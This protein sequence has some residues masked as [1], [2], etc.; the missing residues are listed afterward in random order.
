MLKR[1]LSITGVA[2]GARRR[3][4]AL[5]APRSI[6]S[7]LAR[8]RE[9]LWI[10]LIVLIAGLVHGYNMFGFPYYESDEGTYMSQAWAIIRLGALAPYTYWYDHAPGGWLQIAAWTM[11]TGGFRS[12]GAPINSGRVLML[13]MQIASVFMVYRIA[14]NVSGG[15]VAP[16][17]AALTFAL[18]AYGTYYHRRVVLDNITTCWML[19]SIVLLTEPDLS[20]KRVWLSGLALGISIL[21]KE[22]TIFLV[23][24]LAY[25]VWYRVRG[26]QRWFAV[27]GWVAIV[28]ALFSTYLLLAMLKG[29]LFPSGTWLG[30]TNAHVSLLD[31]LVY[32]TGR[33]R[34]GGLLDL[35]SGFWIAVRNWMPEEPLLLFGGAAGML[36]SVL[37][38]KW[39]RLVG[40]LGLVTISLWVFLGRGGIT[41]PFYLVPLL[42]LLALNL[43]LAVGL[44]TTGMRSLLRRFHPVGTLI[45]AAL[46]LGA[47]AAILACTLLGYSNPHLEFRSDPFVLWRSSQASVNTIA[48]NW[49]I[50]NI[51][52]GSRIIIDQAMWLDLHDIPGQARGFDRA[53]YYWK[54]QGDPAIRNGV[55]QGDWQ[56]AD[57]IVTTNQMLGDIH[58]LDD[59]LL[60]EVLRHSTLVTAF[61]TGGWPVEVRM[62]HKPYLP[63]P[64]TVLA[65]TWASYRA[66]FIEDGRVID[67]SSDGR[68]TSEGQAYALLRAVYV[69]DRQTF[70]AVWDWSTTNLQQPSGLLAWHWGT[71]ADGTTGVIDT[72]TASDADQDAALALLFARKRWGDQR[73]EQAALTLLNGIWEQTTTTAGGRRVLVAGNWARDDATHDPVINPSYFAPYAYR[74]FAEAD[75]RHDWLGLVDSSYDILARIRADARLGGPAGLAPNWV[76]LDATTGALRSASQFGDYANEYSYDASRLPWR[77]AVDQL[78]FSDPRAKIALEGLSLPEQAFQQNGKIAAAYD[79]N[80][81][82]TV[83]HEAISMYAGAMGS[84]MFARDRHLPDQIYT[85]KIMSQYHENGVEAYWGDP[86]GYYDQNWAWFATALVNGKLGN[87]WAG[88][89]E[90]FVH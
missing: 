5:P 58:R 47:V 14:R 60:N 32:Q 10:A 59:P 82:P 64:D 21:S 48:T 23:P 66:H 12:F 57:Y 81:A 7:W 41:L 69:D 72:G 65:K 18:S 35:N 40:V 71:R 3:D 78:W 73:Y 4:P 45:G 16:T 34:D 54:V 30:G 84:L 46:Q 77:I 80:G 62:I 6:G 11:L 26:P 63:T 90:I 55:F 89:D 17:I 22:L 2:G 33:D 25:L 15:L 39:R 20:L 9:A 67:R 1:M 38:I 83:D 51:P 88:K 36:I 56:T 61:D 19:L 13:L 85:G 70:D 75:P 74:I 43:G 87:L 79:I 8:H 44:I 68:T 86:N 49:I 37:V 31:S 29:E 28:G 76:A 50:Q 42:P 53:H 52:P 27:V 24:V